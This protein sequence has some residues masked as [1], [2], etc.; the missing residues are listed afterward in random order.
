MQYDNQK[1]QD[2]DRAYEEILRLFSQEHEECL[3][4]GQDEG[5]QSLTVDR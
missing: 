3:A 2:F 4:M 5:F 1:L